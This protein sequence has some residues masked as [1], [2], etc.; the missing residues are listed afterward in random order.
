MFRD[1]REKERS[2]RN[3][4]YG[5]LAAPQKEL[6]I[7]NKLLPEENWTLAPFS[8]PLV[9]ADLSLYLPGRQSTSLHEGS[10]SGA[11]IGRD[12][13]ASAEIDGDEP[14]DRRRRDLQS[15]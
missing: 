13:P 10:P 11:R 1:T 8:F 15:T 9:A 3:T 2:V 7:N 5:S 6:G 12:A 14:Y 4:L